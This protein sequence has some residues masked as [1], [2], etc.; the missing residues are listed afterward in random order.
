[1]KTK[2]K[3]GRESDHKRKGARERRMR[4]GG[5]AHTRHIL[6]RKGGSAPFE[7]ER[8]AERGLLAFAPLP[9]APRPRPRPYSTPDS[10]GMANGDAA[11]VRQVATAR[12][13]RA[14]QRSGLSIIPPP[15]HPPNA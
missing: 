6:P 15:P 9:L 14:V 7:A 3:S 8:G 1:M 13:K 12:V 2:S 5:S 11:L 10:G 4:M